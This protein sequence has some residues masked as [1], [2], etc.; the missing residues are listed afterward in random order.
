ML[1][2]YT[3]ALLYAHKHLLSVTNMLQL[4]RQIQHQSCWAYCSSQEKDSQASDT[5]RQQTQHGKSL[6]TCSSVVKSTVY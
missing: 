2:L 4:A 1:Q 5:N 6:N 3:L